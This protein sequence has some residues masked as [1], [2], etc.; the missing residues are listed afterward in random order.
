MSMTS[1]AMIRSPYS[2]RP[3]S[4]RG[5]STPVRWRKGDRSPV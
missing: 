2:G 5:L 1:P 4:R 3:H